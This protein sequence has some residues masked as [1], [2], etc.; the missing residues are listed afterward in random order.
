MGAIKYNS[1][2]K[3]MKSS[4]KTVS[5]IL[6]YSKVMAKEEKQKIEASIVKQNRTSIFY[7]EVFG[8]VILN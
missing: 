2:S 8:A 4:K 1:N 3:H 6:H 5:N 7:L